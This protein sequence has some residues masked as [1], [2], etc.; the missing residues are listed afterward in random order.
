M[1]DAT[2][3]VVTAGGGGSSATTGILWSPAVAATTTTFSLDSPGVSIFCQLSVEEA[4]ATFGWADAVEAGADLT[5]VMEELAWFGGG[6]KGLVEGEG[7]QEASA[8]LTATGLIGAG[9]GLMSCFFSSKTAETGSEVAGAAGGAGVE[10]VEDGEAGER[11]IG[12]EPASLVFMVSWVSWK[13]WVFVVS[14]SAWSG[15]SVAATVAVGGRVGG[16]SS[17][18]A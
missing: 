5:A 9:N 6:D 16:L 8:L 17:V 7:V 4:V 13:S 15:V 2:G 11:A 3:L 14:F 1:P 12:V 18:A 10:E